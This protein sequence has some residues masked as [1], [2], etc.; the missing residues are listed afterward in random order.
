MG[1]H[2]C[3][4]PGLQGILGPGRTAATMPPSPETHLAHSRVLSCAGSHLQNGGAKRKL[5]PQSPAHSDPGCWR[6]QGPWVYSFAWHVG[7]LHV[8]PKGHS[9]PV[10]TFSTTG[11]LLFSCAF[12]HVYLILP[13]NI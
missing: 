4:R 11:P 5:P 7:G 6:S 1:N 12:M 8:P 9:A 10:V 2:A 3:S 13:M